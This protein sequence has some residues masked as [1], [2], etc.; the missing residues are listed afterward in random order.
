MQIQVAFQHACVQENIAQY[1][2][3]M[4]WSVCPNSNGGVTSL[5]APLVMVCDDSSGQCLLVED[6]DGWDF[7][8]NIGKAIH[9]ADEILPIPVCYGDIHAALERIQ[10]KI[11]SLKRNLLDFGNG[12]EIS[13]VHRQL[14]ASSSQVCVDITKREEQILRYLYEQR[15]RAVAK[16]EMLAKVWKYNHAADTHT[17]ETHMYRLRQKLA[18]AAGCVEIVSDSDGYA[19]KIV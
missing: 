15:G 7:I 8:V 5:D 11:K 13:S 16:D 17:V 3:R 14:R 18:C 12:W 19:L 1:L 9:G 10:L 4:G 2:R 6:G